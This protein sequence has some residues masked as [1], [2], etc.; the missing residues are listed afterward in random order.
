MPSPGWVVI[1]NGAPRSGKSA[2]VEAIQDSF[3]G[4]WV[5]LGVDVLAGRV[6]P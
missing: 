6:I 4:T 1:L 3:E 5:N 2:I